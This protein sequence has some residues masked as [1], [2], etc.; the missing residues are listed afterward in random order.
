MKDSIEE[1]DSQC[2]EFSDSQ[3][4]HWTKANIMIRG[5]RTTLYQNYAQC[6]QNQKM[7]DLVKALSQ[8]TS[9]ED[10]FDAKA[11]LC[12]IPEKYFTTTTDIKIT[13][14]MSGADDFYHNYQY[15]A[16]YY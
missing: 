2:I 5:L 10:Y 13:D 12:S 15:A 4:K 9:C 14:T 3:I 6:Q 7:H 1:Q 11:V 8:D 16:N